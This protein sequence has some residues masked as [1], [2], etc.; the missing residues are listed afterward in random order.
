MDRPKSLTD[1]LVWCL[2]WL[3]TFLNFT[4]ADV[5]FVWMY[6]F[7]N[8]CFCLNFDFA[9]PFNFTGAVLVNLHSFIRTCWARASFKVFT[10]KHRC[11]I[12]YIRQIIHSRIKITIKNWA[13]HI[14]VCIFVII[15]YIFKSTFMSHL[16]GIS[17]SEWSLLPNCDKTETSNARSSLLHNA[18]HNFYL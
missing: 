12:I 6:C 4:Y 14:K 9:V 11:L 8:L 15:V 1:V 2:N 5:S 3:L 7:H 10:N 16:T 13:Y 18:N 17:M